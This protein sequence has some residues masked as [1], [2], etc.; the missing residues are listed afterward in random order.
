MRTELDEEVV[1]RKW[2]R[3]EAACIVADEVQ[4]SK[5]LNEPGDDAFTVPMRFP[6]RIFTPAS[7]ASPTVG[8]NYCGGVTVDAINRLKV[9]TKCTRG[10]QGG[11]VW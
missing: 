5:A 7:A 2:A 10:I 4:R 6:V 11:I 1:A 8:A 3:A 9:S